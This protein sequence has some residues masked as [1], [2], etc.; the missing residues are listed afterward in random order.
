MTRRVVGATGSW[1]GTWALLVCLTI[2]MGAGVVRRDRVRRARHG[3]PGRGLMS[4]QEP[5]RP[6]N[7]WN[8]EGMRGSRPSVLGHVTGG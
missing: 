3:R 5:S 2:V 4:G 8:P 7:S 6:S 1:R